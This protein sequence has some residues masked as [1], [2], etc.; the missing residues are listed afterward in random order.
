MLGQ[1]RASSTRPLPTVV[2]EIRMNAFGSTALQF[3]LV[4]PRS[5]VADR[6]RFRRETESLLS[7]VNHFYCPA[8]RWPFKGWILLPRRE[9]IQLD[10][11]S[12]ALQLNLGD[13]TN[14][15]NVATFKNLSIV[16]ARCVTRG[17]AADLDA[18]YLIEITDGRGIVCNEWFK[19]PLTS[20]YNIRAP[21]YPQTFH[22]GSMNGGTT[23]TWSTMLQDIWTQMGTFLGAWPGLPSTPNGTPE[24]FWFQGV[25]AWTALC[26]V[27]N[28]LGMTVVC[29][30][31]K[32]SPF[33][34]VSHGAA[35][36][37]FDLLTTKYVTN[38]EDDLEW[39]DTGA[40]RVPKTVKVL[41]RRRN[42]VYSTEETVR[43]TAPQWSMEPLYSVS[44]TAPT[45]FASAVGTHYIWSDFTVRYDMDGVAVAADT[46]TATT[47][48]QERVTQYFAE[49]YDQTLGHMTRVYATALP[50]TTGSQVDGVCWWMDS[51][52]RYGWRTQV[53]RGSSPPWPELYKE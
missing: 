50:F 53:V 46:A 45:T 23:W 21:A 28:H 42:D 38:L 12:T 51:T 2:W 16:N 3:A 19:F 11:Y 17:L 49:I 32:N 26:D 31:T 14:P 27:L 9:Y 4:D 5:V 44:V 37:A 15:D 34:I 36:A 43:L 30:L 29:D 22:P 6:Q 52:N 13:T 25:P 7:H 20:S 39:I 35:D 10:S 18:L 47:I 33:T 41:F 24:A 1:E 8:G 48:A 40:A